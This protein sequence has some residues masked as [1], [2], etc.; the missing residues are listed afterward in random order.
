L[1]WQR[2]G[3]VIDLGNLGGTG[4][5]P[6]LGNWAISINEQGQVVGSS[7]RGDGTN[8]AF[9]WTRQTG[10]QDLGTVPGDTNSGAIGINDE[11]D[12]V[13]VSSDSSGNLRAFVRQNGVL[14][15]LNTLIPAGSPLYL[16]LAN[17]I[18]SR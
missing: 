4:Q 17:S 13:G 7:D 10:M 1:L 6:A 15:D 18:N 11:G 3:T 9:L 2:D 12:V 14:T 8:H 5:A 16:L